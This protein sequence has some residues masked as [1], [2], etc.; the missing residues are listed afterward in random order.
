MSGDL[1]ADDVDLTKE[2]EA[3]D[4]RVLLADWGEQQR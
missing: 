4:P 3:V 1:M 2:P